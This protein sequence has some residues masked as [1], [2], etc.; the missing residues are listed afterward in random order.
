MAR[1]IVA[2]TGASGAIYAAR[3]VAH[4]KGLGQE[5]H[6]VCSEMGKK[7]LAYEGHAGLEKAADKAYD[8]GDLFAPIASGSWRHEGMVIAPCSMGTI[9]KVA[10]GI[11]DTLLTRAADVCLKEKRRLIL[12]PRET[13]MSVI[14][15]ENQRILAAAGAVVL[16]ANPSFYH[17]PQ[18]IEDLVD[19]V[20]SRV[21][22][23]LGLEHEVGKRWREP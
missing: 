19:T 9:G 3:L 8:N 6:C 17:K 14:H 5:V 2:V 18:S 21:L 13:P 11:G 23:Q 7:V 4:L 10:H 20:L 15:L 16:P 12:L 1:V 22:D